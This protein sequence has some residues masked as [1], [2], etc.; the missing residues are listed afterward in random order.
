MQ[1]RDAGPKD[2]ETLVAFNAAMAEETE[3]LVLDERVLRRGVKRLIED[4]ALGRCL[5]AETDEGVV[6][7]LSVTSEW[8]DWR[9]GLFWWIQ[10]VYVAP[11]AR[12]RGVF[13]D[14]YDHVQDLARAEPDVIGLRLYVE[15][16]NVRAQR[17]YARL[18]MEETAYRVYEVEFDAD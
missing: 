18:G 7:T 5:V 13:S 17:T 3:D 4:P 9:C 15:R 12:G 1:I 10:S 6:G 14:L 2:V 11:E 16:N 8:S